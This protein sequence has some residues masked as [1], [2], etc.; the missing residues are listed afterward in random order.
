MPNCSNCGT[1]NDDSARFCKQCGAPLTPQAYPPPPPPPAQG[2]PPP[3]PGNYPPPGYGPQTESGLQQ[4]VAALLCY[5]LGWVSGLIF[6]F[7]DKRP[8]VRF[9]A[10]QSL[11]LFGGIHIL[12]VVLS[13]V[14]LPAMRLWSLL[15]VISSLI[16][17]ISLVLWVLMMVKA[18]QSQWYRLPYI[19]DIALEKS[20][21]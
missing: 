3:P 18:Y 1:L 2:Y 21:Q 12:H 8:F 5:V 6:L 19:G 14:L 15:V 11:I 17:L 20:R 9:H 16:S 13:W 4:N 7:I 10:M